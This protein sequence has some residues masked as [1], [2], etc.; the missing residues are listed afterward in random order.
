MSVGKLDNS[1]FDSHVTNGVWKLSRGSLLV[2]RGDKCCSLYQIVMRDIK[3]RG[4]VTCDG[5]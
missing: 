2:A 5:Y 1:R 3:A 4:V